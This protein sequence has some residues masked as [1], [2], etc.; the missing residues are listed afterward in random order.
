[1]FLSSR[2]RKK[3]KNVKENAWRQKVCVTGIEI[4]LFWPTDKTV[5]KFRYRY[6]IQDARYKGIFI[7]IIIFLLSTFS[8]K[9]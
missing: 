1:M 4:P 9:C 7:I 6:K 5:G 2:K 8:V 3:H